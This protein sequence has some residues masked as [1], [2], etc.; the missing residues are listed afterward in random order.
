[1][2]QADL[3]GVARAICDAHG[4]DLVDRV[5]AGAFKETF[6]ATMPNGTTQALK[7]FQQ[8]N[9]PERTERE[10]DAMVRCDHP[11]IA[12]LSSVDAFDFAGD[13]YLYSLEE[14]LPGGNLT[15][16]AASLLSVDE[17]YA[18]GE[19]L[20]DAVSHI[21][22]HDLVHRDLKPDNIMFRAD[23]TTP[24][25]VD[26]GLVRDLSGT[27]ITGTWLVRGPG[28]P[29]FAAPEQLNNEKELI[30]WRTD[31]FA[32]GIVLALCTFGYHPYAELS[33]SPGQTVER[34]AQRSGPTQ[35]FIEE[36]T[37]GGLPAL[38]H[39]VAPYPIGR[40][41][42]PENL[43]QAWQEQRSTR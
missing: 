43:A 3:G 15:E 21:S 5:G 9:S 22:S 36:S 37:S 4:Y 25:I 38:V 40:F 26:F 39:M 16:R 35:R 29:Y 11:N 33:D 19:T 42:T 10:I 32:L 1:M 8:V 34:T 27:S 7:V 2:S 12:K 18:M 24:V 23:G 41:R 14:Y 6:R 28:S 13:S 20:V 30:D 31:Q 17:T